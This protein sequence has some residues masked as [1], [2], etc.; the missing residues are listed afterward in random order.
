MTIISFCGPPDKDIECQCEDNY[1][2][3]AATQAALPTA[4]GQGMK[5]GCQEAPTNFGD[6]ESSEEEHSDSGESA[7]GD[8][9][10]KSPRFA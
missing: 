3:P 9:R 7:E 1:N 4:L 2:F 5:A 10:S 8:V 6:G